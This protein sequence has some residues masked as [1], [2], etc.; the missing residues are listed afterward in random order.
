MWLFMVT[1]R[2][3]EAVGVPVNGRR[4]WV[5]ISHFVWNV[6]ESFGC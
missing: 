4:E 6:F 3:C 2:E 5:L 1:K